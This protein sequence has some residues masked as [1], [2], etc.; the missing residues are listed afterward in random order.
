VNGRAGPAF[1]GL[2]L[3]GSLHF[4]DECHLR[5]P[6]GWDAP[7]RVF[8]T[9]HI[10]ERICLFRCTWNRSASYVS[11]ESFRSIHSVVWLA[12]E[13]LSTLSSQLFKIAGKLDGWALAIRIQ[14]KRSGTVMSEKRLGG[15]G[16]R[17]GRGRPAPQPTTARNP[18]AVDRFVYG[19]TGIKHPIHHRR[20]FCI[21]EAGLR[22][23][24]EPRRG[25]DTM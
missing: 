6:V 10:F 20:Q 7:P 3:C 2:T 22:W 1:V 8:A 17:R 11:E 24:S 12:G 15:C 25:S 13:L 23:S 21:R 4:N 5:R 9:T 19:M 18:H 16:R 14:G